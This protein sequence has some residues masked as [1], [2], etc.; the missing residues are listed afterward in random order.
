MR[1]WR[2][3]AAPVIC[4]PTPTYAAATAPPHRVLRPERHAAL[5]HRRSIASSA[6]QIHFDVEVPDLD[7]ADKLVLAIGATLL[8][9]DPRGWRIYADP[10]G[11]PFCL[12]A[13]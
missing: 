2:R 8:H 11:H 6:Q 7:Q 3:S 5:D 10:A 13:A 1:I 4:E 12:L 9:A